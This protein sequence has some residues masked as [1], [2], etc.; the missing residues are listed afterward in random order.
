MYT[1]GFVDNSFHLLATYQERLRWR[2]IDLLWPEPGLTKDDVKEW[3]LNNDIRCLMVDYKLRPEF[4][5]F[6]TD[7]VAYINGKLPDLPCIIIT[8]FQADSIS[9]NLVV[10][11]MILER[12]ELD[13]DDWNAFV[14]TLKQAVQVYTKR[15]ELHKEEY[16]ILHKRRMAGELSA[17]EEERLFE[18]YKLLRA[19]GEVDEIPAELL[20]PE[21]GRKMDAMLERLNVLVEKTSQPEGEE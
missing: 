14:D 13:R 2:D 17:I 10:K 5:F 3:I 6:G 7:L 15:L 16:G 12:E 18:L 21:I 8:S 19:Y 20:R 11:N 1:I 9:E 4:D